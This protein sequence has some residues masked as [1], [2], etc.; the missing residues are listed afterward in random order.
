MVGWR[1]AAA[2]ARNE[3]TLPVNGPLPYVVKPVVVATPRRSVLRRL[4]ESIIIQLE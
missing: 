2:L 1:P 4:R 3:R